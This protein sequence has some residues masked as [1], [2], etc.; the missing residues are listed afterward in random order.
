MSGN[1]GGDT[2]NLLTKMVDPSTIDSGNQLEP[3]NRLTS[4][5]IEGIALFN[6]NL[7]QSQDAML[8]TISHRW[9]ALN[10]ALF[11]SANHRLV[12]KIVVFR[13]LMF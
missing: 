2:G 5:S 10:H 7:N 6:Q 4:S 3:R 13:L 1:V 8:I 12:C 9:R 11:Y